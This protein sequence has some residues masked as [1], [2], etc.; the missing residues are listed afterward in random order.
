MKSLH[1]GEL[2]GHGR[3]LVAQRQLA[4]GGLAQRAAGA[5]GPHL[6]RQR[7]PPEPPVHHHEPVRDDVQLAHALPVAVHLLPGGEALGEHDPAQRGQQRR[8][9]RQ[10]RALQRRRPHVRGQP[11]HPQCPGRV[12]AL[13]GL[14]LQAR[15]EPREDAV[16]DW[17]EAGFKGVA[18]ILANPLLRVFREAAF[19]HE[20][21]Q[22]RNLYSHGSSLFI[23]RNNQVAKLAHNISIHG[24]SNCHTNDCISHFCC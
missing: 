23:H 6:R 4:E 17:R 14:R 11:R 13:Q 16:M 3:L 18:K 24:S 19:T 10:G 5:H 1:G 8:R 20:L 15:A 22:V 9:P 21:I 12:H 2:G 7:A